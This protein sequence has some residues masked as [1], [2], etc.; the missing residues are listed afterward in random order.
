[1]LEEDSRSASPRSLSIVLPDV[2]IQCP[3]LRGVQTRPGP[4]GRWNDFQAI[5]GVSLAL[6][7]LAV[8]SAMWVAA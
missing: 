3:S 8:L 5:C 1:M 7:D 6:A 2:M 4:P